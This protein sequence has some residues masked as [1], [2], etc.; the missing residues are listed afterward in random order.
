[1]IMKIDID[2]TNDEGK[3]LLTYYDEYSN[4]TT[5]IDIIL[6]MLDLYI[7]ERRKDIENK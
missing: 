4:Y 6:E 1:M 3:H 7:D 5:L 2:I